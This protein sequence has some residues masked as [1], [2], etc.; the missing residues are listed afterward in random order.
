L[1][2]AKK[3]EQGNL[4][5]QGNHESRDRSTLDE[6]SSERSPLDKSERRA[7]HVH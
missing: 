5:E 6:A 4:W 2:D 7:S 3:S 1:L